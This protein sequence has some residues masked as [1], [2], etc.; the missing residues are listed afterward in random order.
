M[1]ANCELPPELRRQTV[2]AESLPPG[3]ERILSDFQDAQSELWEA[4]SQLRE[5]T[6]EVRRLKK[7]IKHLRKIIQ[8]AENWQKR[9]WFRRA[10]HRWRAE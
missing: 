6:D 3:S 9:S 2:G 1:P 8:S 10:F 7:T 5:Q 4:L